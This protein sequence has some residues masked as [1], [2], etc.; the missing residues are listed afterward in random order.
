MALILQIDTALEKGMIALSDKGKLLFASYCENQKDQSSW[1]VPAIQKMIAESGYKMTDLSAVAVVAGPGSYTGLRVGM[2]TAKG[3]CYALHIPLLTA[4]ALDLYAMKALIQLSEECKKFEQEVLI[5]SMIDARRMEVFMGMYNGRMESVMQ[6]GA[7][8]LDEKFFAEKVAENHIV[9][10]GN[11]VGKWENVYQHAN[12]TYIHEGYTV[13]EF[14]ASSFKKYL[15][16]DFTLL[17]YA[18][19]VYL[20]EVYIHPQN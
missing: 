18:E 8:I 15:Q 14:A 20:K 17:A 6:P 19:P 3:L 12:V 7:I 2:A 11:A 10:C 4:S 16:H 1:L 9:F 13:A 5:C